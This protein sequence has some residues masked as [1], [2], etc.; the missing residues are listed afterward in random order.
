[1]QARGDAL[2]DLT[3]FC[4]LECQPSGPHGGQCMPL[5]AKTIAQ[6]YPKPSPEELQDYYPTV[7]LSGPKRPMFHPKVPALPRRAEQD[8][9][10]ASGTAGA[11]VTEP[12]FDTPMAGRDA[13]PYGKGFT[14][15]IGDAPAPALAPAVEQTPDPN[16]TAAGQQV[17]AGPAIADPPRWADGDGCDSKTSGWGRWCNRPTAAP[18]PALDVS[19]APPANATNATDAN[20]S[21]PSAAANATNATA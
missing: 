16:V 3:R 7:K 15:T 19:A 14:G 4:F 1:M 21:A 13:A 2:V 10:A 12:D 6:R 20:A 18:A 8:L 11:A 17:L 5:T 9:A